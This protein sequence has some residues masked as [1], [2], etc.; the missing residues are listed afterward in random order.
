MSTRFCPLCRTAWTF[1]ATTDN[2]WAATATGL[3]ANID[4]DGNF[5]DQSYNIGHWG[6]LDKLERWA[7]SHPTHLRIFTTFFRVAASLSKL[8]LYHE[9]SVFDARDQ[10]YEY[11]NCH[12]QTGMLRD[13]QPPQ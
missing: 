1:C 3:C 8:R 12:P 9:V 10:R 6:S 13:A 7:E 2:R 4:L 11:I 5:L